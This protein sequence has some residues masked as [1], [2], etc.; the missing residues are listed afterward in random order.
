MCALRGGVCGL[1]GRCGVW[2]SPIWTVQARPGSL[3][4]WGLDGWANLVA[5]RKVA[6]WKDSDTSRSSA[7][8][9]QS[10]SL[11]CP[12]FAKPAHPKETKAVVSLLSSTLSTVSSSNGVALILTSSVVIGRMFSPGSGQRGGGG[13]EVP[14]VFDKGEE[15]ARRLFC[16]APDIPLFAPNQSLQMRIT[17]LGRSAL[18]VAGLHGPLGLTRSTYISS[19]QPFGSTTCT[20]FSPS[21]TIG[22]NVG[23]GVNAG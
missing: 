14:A 10:S 20:M 3:H 12:S 17:A 21:F 15:R 2:E 16:S 4:G 6:S 13:G 19:R 8:F 9:L 1:G 18:L 5:R 11:G 7:S 22:E 23:L